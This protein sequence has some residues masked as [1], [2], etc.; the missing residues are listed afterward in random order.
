MA[1]IQEY[2]KVFETHEEYEEYITGDTM[3]TPNVSYCEDVNDVHY[4][5]WIDTRVIISFNL[6]AETSNPILIGYSVEDE[7]SKVEIDGVVQ[8]NVSS[9]YTFNTLGEHTIKYTLIDPTT[10]VS[11]FESVG[12]DT[13]KWRY[14]VDDLSIIIPDNVTGITNDFG[15]MSQFKHMEIGSGLTYAITLSQGYGQPQYGFDYLETVKVSTN[16]TKY[17]SR[18]NCNAII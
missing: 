5:P 15:L 3:V 4:N 12:A 2:L 9:S 13:V 1:N 14:V 7:C 16:N 6:T 8:P 18:D 11:A 17:D 10:I